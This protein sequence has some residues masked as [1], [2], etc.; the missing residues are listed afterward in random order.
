M[1]KEYFRALWVFASIVLFVGCGKDEDS[2]KKT[3]VTSYLSQPSSREMLVEGEVDIASFNDDLD[4][5]ISIDA[6]QKYQSV[7]G[8]GFA[9]TG[10]SALHLQQMQTDRRAQLL[11]ELFGDAKG[12]IG[13]SFIR[14]SVGASDLDRF[15]FSYNENSA[16]TQH[17]GFSLETDKEY[18]IPT[19][20]QILE[21]NPEI[22]IM[23]SPW[24]AP[25]WMK[26][27]GSFRGGILLPE[28]Y[29]SYA[30]YLAIYIEKM[31]AEGISIDYLTVQNEP[32]HDGNNPSM[33]MSAAEQTAFVRDHL[34]PV[35]EARD[36]QTRIV[37]YDH[38]LDRIDYPISILNDA[39][40][41]KYVDG[42]AF[43]LYGGDIS[44]MQTV[45]NAHPDKHIYFTEQWYS[46]SGEFS[47]DF[48]WH[49]E[50][51]VLGSL[52]NWSRSVIEWNLTSNETFDPHTDGGCSTCLGAVTVTETEIVRNAGYYVMAHVSKFVSPG[53]FR[54]KSNDLD[55]LSQ[56][57]FETPEGR[58]VLVVYN[59][60]NQVHAFNVETDEYAFST[61]M[62]PKSVVTIV[63]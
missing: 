36:V 54:I 42:S 1:L 46:S 4:H 14:I 27:G 2:N 57:A 6:S 47:G 15:P 60:L 5:T 17:D 38:N 44:D 58:T 39:E 59:K 21:I 12:E 52:K 28:F 41:A 19:L 51:I 45:H 26:Q 30:L 16:D 53:S 29:A 11:N 20:K 37:I 7:E 48:Q 32:L 10:G 25:T 43:H 61:R 23:A 40:A 31:Q 22:K 49:I 35:F 33:Y 8:F 24:S 3:N 13:L 62:P 55:G 63:W 9:V 34:G 18:L 50:N 56:V